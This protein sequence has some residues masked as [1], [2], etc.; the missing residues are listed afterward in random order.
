MTQETPVK[1]SDVGPVQ[2][3]EVT[4]AQR[5]AFLAELPSGFVPAVPIEYLE[6]A[7]KNPR[8]GAVAEVVESLRQFGQHRPVV[9]QR[10]T[11]QVIVGNHLLKAAKA[12]GWAELDCYVVDDDDDQAMKR[13]LADNAVGD[14]AG[15]DEAELA[16]VL[17]EVGP[18]PG[19]D[20]GDID[21]L[22]AK[23]QPE[24]DKAEPTYPLVPR[25]NEKYDYVMIFCENET[26]W[27][28]LQTRLELRREK[29]YKSSAVATSH[30]VT[31]ARLQE[32]LSEG[33]G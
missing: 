3:D 21:K 23:L 15:W 22:I 9:V 8:R 26:D 20:E 18:V 2:S 32:L 29:S 6:L 27:T 1:A 12:L 30:V 7:R 4:T 14:K 24:Q 11:A 16:E 31:V 33:N 17:A 10:S 25:L 28:W 5:V 19:F 13:A